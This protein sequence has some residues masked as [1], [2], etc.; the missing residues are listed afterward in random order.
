[1]SE[2]CGIA[3][4]IGV[5]IPWGAIRRTA[6][7]RWALDVKRGGALPITRLMDYVDHAARRKAQGCL[8]F[9]GIYSC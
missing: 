6:L 5:E 2:A 9:I 3:E 8:G 4:H 7:R 1:M